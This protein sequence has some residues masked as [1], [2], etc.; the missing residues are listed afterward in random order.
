MQTV[1]LTIIGDGAIG[2]TALCQSYT[3]NGVSQ[4]YMPTIFDNYAAVIMYN[5]KPTNLCI[6]DTAGQEDYDRLRPLSYHAT[7]CM[8]VCF[9]LVS[10][11]SLR[12]VVAKWGP[13]L[14]Q[15]CPGVPKILVGT[16]C[17]LRCDTAFLQEM[18]VRGLEPVTTQQ[19]QDV[20][21][22]IGAMSYV[23]TSAFTQENL[24]HV[25]Q[26]AL[27]ASSKKKLADQ[28]KANQDCCNVM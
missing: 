10:Q 17:D 25:F 2:K 1:K 21:K 6:F 5:D 8:I 14:E 19:G 24:H 11:T 20:A 28:K 7:D 9:S 23:E 12:N 18:R 22:E 27:A 3:S 16:K 13:E 26:E 4:D 15:Y